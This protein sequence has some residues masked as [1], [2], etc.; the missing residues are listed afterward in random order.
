MGIRFYC[1]NGH[2]LNVKQFQAGMK[3]ICPFCGAKIQIPTESTRRSSKAKGARTAP[4]SGQSVEPPH[5]AATGGRASQP[6]KNPESNPSTVGPV[7]STA[8][9]G[10]TVSPAPTAQTSSSPSDPLAEGG[11]AVWYVRPSSGSQFGPAGSDIMQ[12]WIEEGRVGADSL[13]WREGWRDWQEARE[14]FPQLGAGGIESA[15]GKITTGEDSPANTG[16]TRVRIR[17]KSQTSQA[18]IIILLVL[19]VI[20]LACV[21]VYVLRHEPEDKPSKPDGTGS[22]ALIRHSSP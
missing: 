1:P 16:S 11:D 19:A 20:I 8:A 5:K 6:Q 13:V 10:A 2:K 17:R 4:Q 15:L 14:V 21:F 22:A 7:V 12:T 3:G 18:A 9:R